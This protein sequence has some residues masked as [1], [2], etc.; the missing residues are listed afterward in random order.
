M[1]GPAQSRSAA[2][3]LPNSD[4][5][6]RIAVPPSRRP[7]AE[8]LTDEER[9]ILEEQTRR[10]LDAMALEEAGR[11]DLAIELYE[12]NVEEGFIGDWPY[13][14]LLMVYERQGDY[15]E[16][17]RILRRAIEVTRADRRRPA[18][19]RRT[20]VEGLQGLLRVLKKTAQAAKRAGN[21]R[22]GHTFVPLPM[23]DG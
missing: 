17:E 12:Q 5:S 16:A 19:D 10:N 4:R 7:Q 21:A 23:V 1:A 18:G 6:G 20:V 2:S 22:R 15:A 8:P 14:R 9:E 3:C 13:S 11:M